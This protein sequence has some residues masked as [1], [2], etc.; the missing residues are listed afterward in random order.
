MAENRLTQ[1]DSDLEPGLSVTRLPVGSIDGHWWFVWV[2]R[3]ASTPGRMAEP[4]DFPQFMNRI[5]DAVSLLGPDGPVASSYSG[6]GDDEHWTVT[7]RVPDEGIPWVKVIYGDPGSP[8]GE[9]QLILP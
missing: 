2:F 8:V 7:R 4:D 6:S 1:F 9:E 3:G 5:R